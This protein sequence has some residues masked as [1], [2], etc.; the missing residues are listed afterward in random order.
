MLDY[1][2]YYDASVTA[3]LNA[4]RIDSD[5]ASV[6]ALAPEATGLLY[7]ILA[8]VEQAATADLQTTNNANGSLLDSLSD[9]IFGG[10]T[11]TLEAITDLGDT[12]GSEISGYMQETATW[13]IDAVTTAT[14]AVV[15]EAVDA[16]SG[17][18]D[19]VDAL[20]ETILSGVRSAATGVTDALSN[21]QTAILGVVEPA[22][23]LVQETADG[24]VDQATGFATALRDAIPDLADTLTGA[25][26]AAQDFVVEGIRDAA[27]RII[28]GFFGDIAGDAV[29]R[30]EPLV[31]MFEDELDVSPELRAVTAPGLLPVAAIG[32]L[33]AGFALPMILSSV[34]STALSPFAEKMRQRMNAL[35]RPTLMSPLEAVQSQQRGVMTAQIAQNIL[36][37]QGLPDDQADALRELVMQRPG[38]LEVI[39]YWRRELM[40]PEAADE[41]LYRLGWNEGY[42]DLIREAAYPPPGVG[43]LI[44]MAVREVFS[45]EVAERFGQFDE[46]P[47]DYMMWAKRIGLNDYWAKNY[48]AAHWSL[49]SIMQGFQMLHRDVITSDDLDR[50]F[51]ALDVMPFWRDNLK[52]ISYSPFT[53][54]DV[55][56]MYQQGVI[57]RAGVV[58]AYKDIGYDEDK[59]ELLTQ[60]TVKYVDGLVKV[61]KAKERDLSKADV[62]GLFNDG[63]ITAA[64]TMGYLMQ[65]GYS[66]DEATVLVRREEIQEERKERKAEIEAIIDQAQIK[67][68]SYEQAQ[69]KLASLD[70]STQEMRKAVTSLNRAIAAR[71]RTPSKADLDNWLELGLLTGPEYEGEMGA[72]GYPDKY[73]ALYMEAQQVEA[74]EDLLAAESRAAGKREP[75][76]V[77]KG[78]LDQLYIN[79]IILEDEYTGG[80]AALGY[81]AGDV[82]NFLVA[83]NLKLEEKLAAERDRIARGEE[84]ARKERIP[85]RTLLGKMYLKGLLD[86]AAYEEGLVRLGF[87]PDNVELLKRLIIDKQEAEEAEAV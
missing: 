2:D 60:F 85:N 66:E 38:T 75:R 25:L 61:V 22:L 82:A 40:T 26:D 79:Q 65:L 19:L 72:L 52:A 41:A 54:V 56:R 33:I 34:A 43:D 80:L 87:S 39:D 4:G 37:R 53:R 13:L 71:T 32:G 68:L 12:L 27:S 57:D 10:V 7:E 49:P 64:E 18:V 30:I 84:A 67:V 8:N 9:Q 6:Y 29:E 81:R 31:K 45:P 20:D 46:I 42:R 74:D 69:D 51:V 86:V 83:A 36:D 76:R 5:A 14:A 70:L 55:R 58:R 17:V 24:I 11:T 16:L 48:W 63:V 78:Q 47:L 44:T 1:H 77:T 73:I 15:G 21:A 28:S 3:A 35:A 23:T 62:V 59:A 50:L